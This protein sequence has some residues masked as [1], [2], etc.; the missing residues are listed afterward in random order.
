MIIELVPS[1]LLN[2]ITRTEEWMNA[3]IKRDHALERAKEYYYLGHRQAVVK[4]LITEARLHNRR[5]IQLKRASS[6]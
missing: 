3:I 6:G 1:T 4:A 5:A 2:Y